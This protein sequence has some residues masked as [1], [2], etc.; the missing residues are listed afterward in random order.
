MILHVS[1]VYCLNVFLKQ[2]AKSNGRQQEKSSNYFERFSSHRA[3]VFSGASNSNV[4]CL[5][6]P[7]IEPFSSFHAATL[8]MIQFKMNKLTLRHN[9]HFISLWGSFQTL[10]GTQLRSKWSNLGKIRTNPGCYACLSNL[11]V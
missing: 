5:N 10:K 6:V 8:M 2:E 11:Q 3:I 9:F 1:K 4:S 7:Q